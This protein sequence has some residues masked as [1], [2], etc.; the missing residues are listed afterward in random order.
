[1][2]SGPS[3]LSAKREMNERDAQLI[4]AEPE[5]LQVF[6]DLYFASDD[7]AGAQERADRMRRWIMQKNPGLIQD[8]TQPQIPPE[9][10]VQIQQLMQK[11]QVTDAFAQSL[12]EKLQTK[13]PE[14]DVRLQVTKMQEDTKK[15]IALA[16][17]NSEE[18]LAKLEQELN[19]IH[20]KVDQAHDLRMKALDQQAAEQAQTQPQ[21]AVQ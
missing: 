11:L 4:T 21:E 13:Q 10:Q 6:G 17:L 2:F 5:L 18:A 15:E 16:K 1:M 3:A 8:A 7:T 9:V 14:L 20:K 19:I 12:H